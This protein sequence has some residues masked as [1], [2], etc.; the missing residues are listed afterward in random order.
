MRL[1]PLTIL[2]IT[3]CAA[4]TLLSATQ[5]WWTVAFD[6]RSLEVAGTVAS[7]AL[8]VLALSSL[9]LAAALSLAGPVFRVI[10]GVL[11]VLLGG[12]IVFVAVASLVD[13]VGASAT[14]ISEAS[15]VAG[16]KS[17]AGLVDGVTMTPWPFVGVA[18]GALALLVGAALLGTSRRWPAGTR[19]YDAVRLEDPAAPRDRVLDWD[20]LSDGADPTDRA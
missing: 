5:P 15:G 6:G 14:V 16:A 12:T 19:K 10:L 8:S 20:A 7:P 11:Q 13:A 17:I 9:A 1:R 3:A 4:L 2:A 18:S